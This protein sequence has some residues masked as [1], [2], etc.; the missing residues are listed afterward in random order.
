MGFLEVRFEV[1]RGGGGEI[2]Y[3]PPP[4]QCLK[5]VTIMLET[6]NLTRRYTS[7][8]SFRKYTFQGLGPLNFANVTIFLQKITVFFPKKYLYS[9]Q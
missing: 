1:G 4:P 5:P 8:C 6:S 9:K 3:T 7:I 2:K